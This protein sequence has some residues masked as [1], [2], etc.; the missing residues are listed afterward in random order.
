V[1][2]GWEGRD[3]GG[4]GESNAVGDERLLFGMVLRYELMRKDVAAASWLITNKLR[5]FYAGMWLIVLLMNIP[6]FH[7]SAKT[8]N[9]FGDAAIQDAG[10]IFVLILLGVFLLVCAWFQPW[11]TARRTILRAVEWSV[12]DEGVEVQSPVASARFRWEAFL[13]FREDRKV[14]LLYVQKGQAQFIP[15]RVLSAEQ[16]VELREI[17]SRHVKKA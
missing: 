12:T 5:Y 17:V 16:L 3:G 9:T 11:L 13:K 6:T 8:A 4:C 1:V 10:L 2:A 14:F 15:T 7:A